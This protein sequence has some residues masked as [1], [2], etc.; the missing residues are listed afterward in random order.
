MGSPP[1]ITC[2][3]AILK[4]GE[5]AIVQYGYNVLFSAMLLRVMPEE[6]GYQLLKQSRRIG[7]KIEGVKTCTLPKRVSDVIQ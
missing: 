4:S 5:Y 6:D 3:V 7:K 2:S 1:F